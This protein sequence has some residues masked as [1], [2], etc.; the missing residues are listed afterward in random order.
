[1]VVLQVRELGALCVEEAEAGYIRFEMHS[2][3]EGI[4]YSG[5]YGSWR[6]ETSL[7]TFLKQLNQFRVVQFTWSISHKTVT[8][9]DVDITLKKQHPHY[10]RSHKTYQPHAVFTHLKF[11]SLP[12]QESDSFLP[13]TQRTTPEFH[14]LCD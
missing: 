7:N 6:S 11:P 9:L 12:H 14:H 4:I 5:V 8:L 3:K 13:C 10:F 1:M 2:D